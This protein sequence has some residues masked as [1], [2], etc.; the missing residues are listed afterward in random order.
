MKTI[1]EEYNNIKIREE[2]YDEENGKIIQMVRDEIK[3]HFKQ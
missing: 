1:L 2:K 3:K